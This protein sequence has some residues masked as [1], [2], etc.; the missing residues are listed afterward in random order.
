MAYT[1]PGQAFDHTL[2]ALKG[3]YQEYSLD[4]EVKFSSSVNIASTGLPA[5][6]GLVVHAVSWESNSNPYGGSMTGPK[7]IVVEMGCGAAH[8]V[9]MFLWS[10]P[11][12]PDVYNPGTPTGVPPYGTTAYPADFYPVLPAIVNGS[13]SGQL[14]N[15]LVAL[16]GYELETTEYDHDQ[17]YTAGNGLRSV[18]S[19]TDANAGRVT[20]Q[21]GTTAAYNS[22][23]ATQPVGSANGLTAWDT[24]VGWVSRGEYVNSYKREALAFYSDYLPGTR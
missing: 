10:R 5:T 11:T 12:D 7:N 1:Y 24:I 20:N 13:N 6:P 16:G 14:M 9:P 17:T 8:G 3:W 15:A 4:A 23:G 18:T 22:A 2:Q 21:R 19:N